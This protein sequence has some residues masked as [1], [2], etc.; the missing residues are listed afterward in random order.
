MSASPWII[1]TNQTKKPYFIAAHDFKEARHIFFDTKEEF[2][3]FFVEKINLSKETVEKEIDE[4]LLRDP[5]S[6]FNGRS[7]YRTTTQFNERK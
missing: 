5:N 2:I 4:I 3:S 1:M 6:V 7:V